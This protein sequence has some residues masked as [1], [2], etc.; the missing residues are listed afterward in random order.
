MADEFT[1][2]THLRAVAH[3]LVA[4]LVADRE[5]C[6]VMTVSHTV[7]WLNRCNAELEA[8]YENRKEVHKAALAESLR[9]LDEIEDLHRAEAAARN[10]T[11]SM[12]AEDGSS[13]SPHNGSISSDSS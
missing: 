10:D 4:E 12:N 13:M 9:E 2:A 8:F 6:P 11:D 7:Q 3:V 1:A 5:L